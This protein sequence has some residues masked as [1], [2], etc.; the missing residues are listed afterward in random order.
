MSESADCADC[1]AWVH[2]DGEW[3]ERGFCALGTFS[4]HIAGVDA[5]A[6]P[7]IWT[8]PV[9]EAIAW[10]RKRARRVIVRYVAPP[11]E[12]SVFTAGAQDARTN[13]EVDGPMVELPRWPPPDLQLTPG[14]NPGWEFMERTDGEEPIQWEVVL[15]STRTEMRSIPRR[16]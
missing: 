16:S 14:R 5:D 7:S 6:P 1:L 11:G 9:D 12:P 13:L 3:T 15:L 4:A 10:A 8:V 2:E